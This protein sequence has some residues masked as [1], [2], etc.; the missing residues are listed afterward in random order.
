LKLRTAALR[1]NRRCCLAARLLAAR[2]LGVPLLCALLGG[3]N[4]LPIADRSH[5]K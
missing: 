5:Q 1:A 3:C 2:T 4:V